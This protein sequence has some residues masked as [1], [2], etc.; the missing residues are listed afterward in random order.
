MYPETDAGRGI[1]AVA[2]LLG[3]FLMNV[4]IAFVLITFDEVYSQRRMREVRGQ[5]L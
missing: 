5:S 1:A 2:A 4:P 3:V